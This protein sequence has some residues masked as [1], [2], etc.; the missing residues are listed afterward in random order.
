MPTQSLGHATLEIKCQRMLPTAFHSLDVLAKA[1]D[2]V[3]HLIKLQHVFDSLEKLSL[4][5]RF[6][7]KVIGSRLDGSLDVAQLIQRGD[8]EN[9]DV[10]GSRIA[11]E[12]FTNLEAAQLGHHD[13]EQDQMRMERFDFVK[14]ILPVN[15]HRSLDI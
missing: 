8:H 11:L 3:G 13:I 5:Y 6:G 2:L 4:I 7:Q 12:L 1:F 9:H 15:G 14:R 10:A